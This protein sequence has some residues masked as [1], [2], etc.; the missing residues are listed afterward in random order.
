MIVAVGGRP[1]TG[2][3][4]LAQALAEAIPGVLLDKAAL[5]RVLFPEL[6]T[7]SP[8]LNDRLYEWLLQAAA[9]QLDR[10]PGTVIVLDGRPLTRIRDVLS[11]RRFAAGIGHALHVVECVCPDTVAVQ[12]GKRADGREALAGQ[13]DEPAEPI[14]EPKI[15]VDTL[16]SPA[17]CLRLA[18][19]KITAGKVS[20]CPDSP[21]QTSRATV[22]L[23]ETEAPLARSMAN[24]DGRENP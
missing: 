10:E 2:K 9:W 7:A 24:G 3:T 6:V 19:N 16:L 21:A 8:E 14:P 22:N 12:R 4:T 15:V 1:L 17:H 5:R 20:G 23:T 13:L 11:L 18:L